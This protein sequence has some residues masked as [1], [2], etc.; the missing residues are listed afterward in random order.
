MSLA[1]KRHLQR[2]A[3][4]GA[5]NGCANCSETFAHL[6]HMLTD[7]TPGRKP[8][9]WL[10]MPLCLECHTGTHGIHG[11]RQRWTLRKMT[12]TKALE[13]TLEGVYGGVR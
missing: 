8:T 3:D 12:E 2:V 4:W 11:T 13:K 7:R 10:V 5:A 9:G 1:E 6:H